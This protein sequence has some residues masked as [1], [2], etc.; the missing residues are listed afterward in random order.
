MTAIEMERRQKRAE[1]EALVIA[2]T[3]DGYRVHSPADPS[4]VYF[5][6][7]D[8][9]APICTCPDFQ[10]Y[11]SDPD[12]K[13]KHVLA[14]LDR[15]ARTR[16]AP[17]QGF[18]GA[19]V[20]RFSLQPPSGRVTAANRVHSPRSCVGRRISRTSGFIGNAG[21]KSWGHYEVPGRF[22]H[23]R[24]SRGRKRGGGSWKATPEYHGIDR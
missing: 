13:C 14:V 1:T 22:Q 18:F 5:V 7:G 23:P 17:M 15:L 2:K 20:F 9:E 16:E 21:G 11:G 8:Q 4:R 10:R 24:E 3:E 19:S 6:S 12:W